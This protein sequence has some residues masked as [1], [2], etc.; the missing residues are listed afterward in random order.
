MLEAHS[1]E[2]LKR[3]GYSK[4]ALSKHFPQILDTSLTVAKKGREKT[5][6]QKLVLDEK[7]IMRK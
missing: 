3:F 6:L 2:E 1:H 4:Q 7:R 5:K